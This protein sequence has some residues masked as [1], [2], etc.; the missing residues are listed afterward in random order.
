MVNRQNK[1]IRPDQPLMDPYMTIDEAYSKY[2][3]RDKSFRF[4]LETATIMEDGKPVWPDLQPQSNIPMLV[5]LKYFDTV[6]Q[7]LLGVGHIY[8]KK[9][10]KVSEMVPMIL[11]LMGW[12]SGIPSSQS[13]G[14]SSSVSSGNSSSHSGQS[15]VPTLSLFEVCL[16]LSTVLSI[17]DFFLIMD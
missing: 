5:F 13:A 15:Q 12:S 11:Q 1:T 9:H 7:S 17:A 3:T 4:W 2:G 8:V 10:S 6:S 16:H 14:R